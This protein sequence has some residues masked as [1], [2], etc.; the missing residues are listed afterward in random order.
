M[1]R[2]AIITAALLA[3]APA[4]GQACFPADL[5]AERLREQSGEVRMFTARTGEKRLPVEITIGPDGD[6]TVLVL[7]PDGAACIAIGG[8]GFTPAQPRQPGRGS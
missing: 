2:L 1:P 3:T 6:W 8:D 4:L 5:L 7:R